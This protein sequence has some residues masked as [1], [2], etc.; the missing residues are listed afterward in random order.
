MRR[1]SAFLFIITL[2][3]VFAADAGHEMPIY[4][5]Y[6]PQEIRIEPV[7]PTAAG[8]ALKEGRIQAYVGSAP[9]FAGVPGK[10]LKSVE[11][12]GAFVVVDVNPKSPLAASGRSACVVAETVVG[13]LA[14]AG[15]GFRFHP[16][17]V[18]GLHADY[19]HHFDRAARAKSRF[20]KPSGVAPEELAVR[21]D[22][23]LPE[24]LVRERWPGAP[25]T[26]DA[27]V[28]EI[29]LD[30]L[31]AGRRLSINGWLGPPWL[32]EGWF[33]AYLLLAETLTDRA[34]K[35]RAEA[36]VG[37]LETGAFDSDEQRINLERDLVSLLTAGCRRTVAGYRIRREYYNADFSSGVENI[38][39]DSHA[40]FNS[41]IFIRTVKLKDFPWN[42]WLALGIDGTPKAAW[43]PIAGFTDESGRLIWWALGDPAL[44]PEPYGA[45]WTL[46][47]MGAL[48][49][50]RIKRSGG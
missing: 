45:G 21:A 35:G 16:Y 42:G 48:G 11:T 27:T 32:K 7:T 33:H 39:Y 31:L 41:A 1:L 13:A 17:P 19:L 28:R 3:M 24:K 6:Y 8:P 9:A 43:N 37:R 36:L 46:N 38:A 25:A 14:K 22:G 47:R 26:W 15:N 10:T 44:F 40:G 2:M 49:E 30:R 5:S 20:L 34:A 23:T 50:T 12:L 29:D 18:N 4:P